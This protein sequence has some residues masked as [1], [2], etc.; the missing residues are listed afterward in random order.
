LVLFFKKELLALLLPSLALIWRHGK[1]RPMLIPAI[2]VLGV[3]VLVGLALG[4][5][6]MMVDAPPD[7]LTWKGA[8]HGLGGAAGLALLVVALRQAPP[9]THA[10]KMGV[11]GFGVFAACLIGAAFVG[12][13]FIFSRHLLRRE[14]PLAAVAVHGV[15]AVVGYT[16]LVT[17]LTMLH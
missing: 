3:V 7:G 4:G 6:Y 1:P 10:V 14:V 9:S 16:L 11:A 2:A 15:L 5:L 13:L 8:A 12:G 17:Y